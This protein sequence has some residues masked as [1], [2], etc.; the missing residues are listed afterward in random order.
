MNEQAKKSALLMIPYGLQVLGAK[1]GDQMTLAT[2]NWTTQASFKP[3]LVVVGVKGD[4]SAHGMVKN[5][6]QF[7]MSFLGAGQKGQAFAFFKHVEPEG[8]KMG[9]FAYTTGPNTG[10]P[11]ISDA[12]AWVEC[13]VVGFYEHGDHTVVVGEVIEGGLRDDVQKTVAEN[14]KADIEALTLKDI[15]AKYG[16]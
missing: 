4:S 3:P 2:V 5:S 14:P 8:G 11:I 9:G 13:K 15:G 1:D 10:C 12:P 16:G 7:T 6:K